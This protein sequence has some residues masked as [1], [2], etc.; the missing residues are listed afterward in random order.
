MNEIKIYTLL[1]LS[2]SC[3]SNKTITKPKNKHYVYAEIIMKDSSDIL[4]PI[5]ND[6]EF[7]FGS[8]CA[9]KNIKGDTVIP[10]GIYDNWDNTDT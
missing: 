9:F 1:F 5:T 2:L 6:N 7:K 8:N 4:I 10:F 3:T